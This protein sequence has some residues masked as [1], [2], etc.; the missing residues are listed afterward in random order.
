MAGRDAYLKYL[1]ANGYSERDVASALDAEEANS[2]TAAMLAVI[3]ART[4]WSDIATFLMDTVEHRN[5]STNDILEK[6]NAGVVDRFGLSEAVFVG[7]FPSTAFDGQTVATEDGPL[8]LVNEGAIKLIGGVVQLLYS[9]HGRRRQA[10]ELRRMGA[11]YVT[12]LTVPKNS[13]FT[14]SWVD[15][16]RASY[17]EMVQL[18]TAVE[19]FLLLHEYGHVHLGLASDGDANDELAADRWA[20]ERL[21]NMPNGPES[22]AGRSVPLS[23]SLPPD[24]GPCPN[25]GGCRRK[26]ASGRRT[27]ACS[28]G[29]RADPGDGLGE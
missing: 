12:D 5:G 22:G 16:D 4:R 13:A 10:D 8:I 28:G 2:L 9:R 1:G 29:H 25:P 17:Q 7:A 3:A 6:I 14:G 27:A 26:D 24:G 18:G 21:E 19:A 23:R 15:F 11:S 20:L